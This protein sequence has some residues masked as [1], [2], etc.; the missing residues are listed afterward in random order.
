MP[1][2]KPQSITIGPLEFATNIA[3]NYHSKAMLNRY[4]P[5]ERLADDDAAELAVLLERHSE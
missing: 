2:G 1:R 3:A 4:R 5:G